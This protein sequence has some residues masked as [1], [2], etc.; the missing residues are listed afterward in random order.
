MLSIDVLG[1]GRGLGA[2][3]EKPREIELVPVAR[4]SAD[5]GD[6]A[7]LVGDRLRQVVAKGGVRQVEA[8]RRGFGEVP[9][10]HPVARVA[11]ARLRFLPREHGA[12]ER[13]D[14]RGVGRENPLRIED[15]GAEG[16][17]V[18]TGERGLENVEF[19]RVPEPRIF[20][21]HL[22]GEVVAERLI[23]GGELEA[24]AAGDRLAQRR[25]LVKQGFG[26]D[27]AARAFE[28][29]GEASRRR[30]D[31]RR[32]RGEMPAGERERLFGIG[33][34][35]LRF[36]LFAQPLCARRKPGVERE[37]LAAVAPDR[38]EARDDGVGLGRALVVIGEVAEQGEQRTCGRGMAGAVA[39]L[40]EREQRAP[41]GF[42]L[43][44][45]GRVA[46]IVDARLLFE[47]RDLPA[48]GRG[49][50]GAVGGQGLRRALGRD[51][52]VA[53]DELRRCRRRDRRQRR[54][55]PRQETAPDHQ[56]A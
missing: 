25:R 16:R 9:Q 37:R 14:A 53:R 36:A 44:L 29:R 26:I 27:G 31:D 45:P 43:G 24:V 28:H 55:E 2:L 52:D 49:R 22:G 4:T 35:G 54:D 21:A 33:D 48:L 56:P 20:G 47:R 39:G 5:R 17:R 23:G 12:I 32:V 15:D 19:A 38:D 7:A 3:R 46:C 41:R 8:Q 13:I 34:G 11:A 18:G 30:C 51:H 10:G 40:V 6:D 1:L 42:E 50:C